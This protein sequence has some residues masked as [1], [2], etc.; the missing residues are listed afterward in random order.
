MVKLK[1]VSPERYQSPDGVWSA[2]RID[3]PE[4][5]RQAHRLP[6]DTLWSL[7]SALHGWP[8]SSPRSQPAAPALPLSSA[9]AVKG[10]FLRHRSTRPN[11]LHWLRKKAPCFPRSWR[12]PT[13]WR[14][15]GAS[16]SSSLP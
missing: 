8:N 11:W 1:S 9:S 3:D 15:G 7:H 6:T 10:K 13:H 5:K 2:V 14:F 4:L 12:A 16:K